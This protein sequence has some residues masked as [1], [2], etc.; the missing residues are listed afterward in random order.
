MPKTKKRNFEQDH[1]TVL[2]VH[3]GQAIVLTV[4]GQTRLLI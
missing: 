4:A 2:N 1:R 3:L